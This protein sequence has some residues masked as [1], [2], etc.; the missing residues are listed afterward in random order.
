SS[1]PLNTISLDI[2]QY[3][4]IIPAYASIPKSGTSINTPQWCF[5]AIMLSSGDTLKELLVHKSLNEVEHIT[6][7]SLAQIDV[8]HNFLE[9]LHKANQL[10]G[11][12]AVEN[13]GQKLRTS[14]TS[15]NY[16]AYSILTVCAVVIAA[17]PIQ[18]TAILASGSVVI[19]P[20]AGTTTRFNYIANVFAGIFI[21]QFTQQVQTIEH[22]AEHLAAS[23]A[24][25]LILSECCIFIRR[26]KQSENDNENFGSKILGGV[27]QAA[28]WIA[29]TLH[30]VL[31]TETGPVGMIHPGIGGALGAGANLAGAVDRLVNKS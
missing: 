14:D 12:H 28:Q 8:S 24:R 30:K 20:P 18:F 17:F 31:S 22:E 4:A 29:P 5:P 7:C 25:P 13:P 23:G 10:N 1:S 9:S 19:T 16:D 6:V 26:L 2:L 11:L 27:K 21:V 15:Y 3:F